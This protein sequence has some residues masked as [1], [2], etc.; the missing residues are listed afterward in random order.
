[1]SNFYN[2][3]QQ[4]KKGQLPNELKYSEQEREEIDWAKVQYNSFYKTPEYFAS[5]FPPE[6]SGNFPAFEKICEVMAANT[7]TP[8]EEIE[9][10][11]A[12]KKEELTNQE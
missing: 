1:M 4:L 2:I 5:K 8:L 10:R 11:Q 3:V 7:K 12:I 9:E 6:W